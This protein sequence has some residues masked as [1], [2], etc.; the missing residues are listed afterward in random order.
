MTSHQY[1]LHCTWP[2]TN[3]Y[4]VHDQ[5]QTMT[6]FVPI[7]KN[8]SLLLWLYSLCVEE[9]RVPGGICLIYYQNVLCS[10]HPVYV[11]C[12]FF[13]LKEKKKTLTQLHT[14]A[15]DVF[16]CKSHWL[17][18]EEKFSSTGDPLWSYHSYQWNHN[19]SIKMYNTKKMKVVG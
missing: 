8:F 19:I 14:Q 16:L 18:A 12:I 6:A 10:T 2:V 13:F 1:D 17:Q 3:K 7:I 9:I 5:L 4:I 11:S 15:L